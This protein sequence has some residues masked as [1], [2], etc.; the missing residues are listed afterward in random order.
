[1]ALV[2]GLSV[3]LLYDARAAGPSCSG[4]DAY[5]LTIL[6][7]EVGGT[8]KPHVDALE[9]F[10]QAHRIHIPLTSNSHVR[11]T[12]DCRPCPMKVGRAY[13][14]NNQ[15]MHSVMNRGK[16]PRVSFIFDYCP[17]KSL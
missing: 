2:E 10:S 5:P 12:V 15:K 7:T 3:D 9:S 13:E 16:E 6:A 4:T 11:F 1:M 14:I 17:P 8:I